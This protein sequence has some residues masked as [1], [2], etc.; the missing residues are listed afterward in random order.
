MRININV[1]LQAQK[2]EE[3]ARLAAIASN[4]KTRGVCS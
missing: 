2:E 3:A 1:Y 4:T